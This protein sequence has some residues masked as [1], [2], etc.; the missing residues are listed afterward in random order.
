MELTYEFYNFWGVTVLLLFR[1]QAVCISVCPRGHAKPRRFRAV[2]AVSK[3]S[4]NNSRCTFLII[5]K[6]KLMWP[7]AEA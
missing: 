6:A 4:L 2:T 1:S 3:A 5:V 7:L